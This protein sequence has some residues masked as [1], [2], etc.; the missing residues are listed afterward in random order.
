MPFKIKNSLF[1]TNTCRHNLSIEPVVPQGTD[2]SDANRESILML[3]HDIA[4]DTNSVNAASCCWG[5]NSCKIVAIG[6]AIGQKWRGNIQNGTFIG[7]EINHRYTTT[8]GC[9]DGG[10]RNTLFGTC[11]GEFS[12]DKNDITAFGFCAALS[13]SNKIV[14]L[15]YAAGNAFSCT[16]DGT[17]KMFSLAGALYTNNTST[18]ATENEILIGNNN[19]RERYSESN[20]CPFPGGNVSIGHDTACCTRKE[21][22]NNVLI[23]NCVGR[24]N[25]TIGFRRF[26]TCCSVIVGK[27]TG[28]GHS[29]GFVMGVVI[30]NDNFLCNTSIKD[31]IV[32][33]NDNFC[34]NFVCLTSNCNTNNVFD[35]IIVGNNVLSPDLSGVEDAQSDGIN[36]EVGVTS[37]ILIGGNGGSTQ[38][39]A[40]HL[41]IGI[42]YC[43]AP[44]ARIYNPA[45]HTTSCGAVCGL[46]VIGF[47]AGIAITSS[48]HCNTIIGSYSGCSIDNPNF[49]S[50]NGQKNVLIG[51]CSGKD[52]TTGYCNT[53][54][55]GR[56]WDHGSDYSA[57]SGLM[58]RSNGLG[59]CVYGFGAESLAVGFKARMTY[60]SVTIGACAGSCNGNHSVHIGYLA[61]GDAVISGD[62][63]QYNVFVGACAGYDATYGDCNIA[64]GHRAGSATDGLY[65]LGSNNASRRLIIGNN[66]ISN[67]YTKMA[68]T[69][70]GGNAVYWDSSTKELYSS[71]SSRRYKENIRPFLKGVNEIY[72]IN[73]VT[74]TY[75]ERP[76]NTKPILGLIAEDLDEIGLT[77]LVNYNNDNLPESISYDKI[78]VL[79]INK[80]K[81]LKSRNDEI[82]RRISLLE[83]A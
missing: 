32:I 15:G 55:G 56:V 14:G 78:N 49:S 54:V 12:R 79:L 50:I 68:A 80:I 43:A 34:R 62:A 38:E 28:I 31:N 35:N 76:E 75:I 7:N 44:T 10:L 45:V 29:S 65:A 72:N 64:I 9:G 33:G 53:A 40:P 18:V 4:S 22:G 60:R 24:G 57:S 51:H 82:N 1:P 23:G 58:N 30:G 13:A 21:T 25:N 73:P 17:V 26:E 27:C 46:E 3:G 67:F 74:F 39:R 20:S 81:N 48:V 47:S 83:T 8:W 11:I 70:S 37:S 6:N 66:C 5:S 16:G 41:L 63:D 77:E 42:G 59:H 61:G 71:S 36:A 2:I 52:I 19:F 69:G